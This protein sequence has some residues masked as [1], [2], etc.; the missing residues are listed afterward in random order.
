MEGRKKRLSILL[1]VAAAIAAVVAGTAGARTHVHALSGT[2][3]IYGYGPGDDVQENRAAYAA[4]QL[5]GV[6]IKREAPGFDDQAFLTRL[7]SG[8]IPDLVRMPRP[9]LALYA[10]KGVL[11]PVNSCVTPD[12]AK[13]Y[14]AGAIKAMTYGGK[15]YGLPEFTNQVTLVVNVQAFQEA[16]VPLSQA[17]TKNLPQLL[18]TAKKLTKFDSSGNLVRIGFDPKIDSGFGFPLWV[19]YFGKSIISANGLKAQINQPAAV[20]A[21]TFALQV[22]NA[23][24]GWN[25][26]VAYRN[27]FD[28][29]GAQNPLVK[30]QLGFWPMESF[31]YNVFANNSPKQHIAARYFQNQKGGPITFFSG[32]GWAIPKGSKNFDAACAYMKA[33]T[34][35]DAWDLAGAKRLA[36]RRA[37]NPPQAFTGLY[38]ANAVA[39]KKLYEDVY[40]ATGNP[41]YDDAVKYLVNASKYGFE[42]PPTPAGAQFANAYNSA[43]QRVLTR[44]QTVKA[45]L[46]QAQKEAQAAIDANK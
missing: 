3:D 23:E 6:T 39:D 32:N 18:K 10:A 44:Q 8:D 1:V 46:A 29:F 22:I 30:D 35:V 25:K 7:A 21:L 43:I 45:A 36:A 41:D 2:L 33:V 28:F 14:R 11:Q 9:S 19:K 20:K 42:L 5:Q 37:A 27:T 38:T 15:L 12:L 4:A 34:S 16:G 24:G 40:H 31:I 26:F 13:Q 17:Q